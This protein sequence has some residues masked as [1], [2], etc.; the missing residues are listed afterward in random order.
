M[1]TT[2]FPWKLKAGV[3]QWTSVTQ[4]SSSHDQGS[5]VSWKLG[6]IASPQLSGRLLHPSFHRGRAQ[7]PLRSPRIPTARVLASRSRDGRATASARPL[8]SCPWSLES[9]LYDSA[10]VAVTKDHR[11]GDLNDNR[12]LPTVLEVKASIRWLSSEPS[13]W[14]I[15]RRLLASCSQRR[16]SLCTPMS[17]SPPI[18]TPVIED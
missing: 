15:D 16:P 8:E 17:Q 12:Y 10:R 9:P 11:L 3:E 14:L 4:D 13:P 2:K 7:Q 1:I 18:R 5:A 6:G